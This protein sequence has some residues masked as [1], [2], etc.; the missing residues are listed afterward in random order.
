MQIAGA[1]LNTHIYML[2]PHADQALASV[3]HILSVLLAFLDLVIIPTGNQAKTHS[4]V[5]F[6]VDLSANCII[7][8]S[9]FGTAL[10]EFQI[11]I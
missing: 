10:D 6:G 3:L 4:Y 7:L 1:V 8:S 2:P 11:I 5:I 9:Y